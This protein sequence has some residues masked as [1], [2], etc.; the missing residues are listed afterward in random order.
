MNTISKSRTHGKS[1][2]LKPSSKVTSFARNKGNGKAFQ[3]SWEKKKQQALDRKQFLQAK[4]EIKQI[5][6]SEK[7][8]K[9]LKSEE[10]AKKR[11]ENELKNQVAQAG[12]KTKSE[13]QNSRL[14]KRLQ[15]QTARKLKKANRKQA[16]MM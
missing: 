4:S 8:E 7:E 13:Q 12:G 6:D 16:Q 15:K 14:V 2:K 9:R 10:K 3:S 1:W 11:E 5:R